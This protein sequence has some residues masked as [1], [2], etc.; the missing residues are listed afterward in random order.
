MKHP[1]IWVLPVTHFESILFGIVL[2]FQDHNFYRIR[3]RFYFM[4]AILS[5]V[6]ILL[7]PGTDSTAFHLMILYPC[8]GIAS[9][10]I[11][12]IALKSEEGT[13][14]KILC[15][16]ILVFLGKISFGLYVFHNACI[17]LTEYLFRGSANILIAGG[18]LMLTIIVA[19]MSYYFLERRF[20]RMKKNFTIIPSRPF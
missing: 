18:S 4:A 11:L 12:C 15:G 6:A 10:S 7:L 19:T 20:L 1:A 5:V 13:L 17:F 8:I 9:V 2:G 3:S 16:N 14:N